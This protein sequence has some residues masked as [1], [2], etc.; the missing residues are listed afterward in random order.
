MIDVEADHSAKLGVAR[1]QGFVRGSCMAFAASDLNAA[2]HDVGHLS[3][4]YLCHHAAKHA[5]DWQPG[6]GFTLSQ[7]LAAVKA[8]GQPPESAYPYAPDVAD[9]PLHGVPGNAAPLYASAARDRYL[10]T[11]AAI[12]HVLR[13]SPVGVVVGMSQ[14]FYYPNGGV[15]DF[16]PLAIPDLYHALIAVGVGKHKQTSETHLLVRN[17]WGAGWGLNGHA[18]VPERHLNVHLQEAF[19]I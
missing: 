8:P 11:Q 14:S 13:G 10:D 18:W 7:V 6:D 9:R 15:V 16:D 19:L 1:H 2:A 5:Q 12:E 4:D 17:S 3:V